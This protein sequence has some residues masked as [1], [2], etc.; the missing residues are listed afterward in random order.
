MLTGYLNLDGGETRCVDC[1]IDYVVKLERLTPE[2]ALTSI[3]SD[4]SLFPLYPEDRIQENESLL[5]CDCA[6]KLD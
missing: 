6:C 3:E 5:C 2:D 1:W 4:E